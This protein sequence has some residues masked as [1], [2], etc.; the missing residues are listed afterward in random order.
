MPPVIAPRYLARFSCIGGA[1][2]DTCCA[3]W[4]IAID[5]DHY[6]KM[7]RA[8]SQT[9]AERELFDASVKRLRSGRTEA[10]FALIVL[11]QKTQ[12]CNFLAEDGLCGLQ[13]RHGEATLPHICVTYPRRQSVV[14]DR[15]ESAATLSCPEAARLALLHPDAMELV[16]LD[17]SKTIARDLWVQIA[18]G[19]DIYEQSLD[20]V[21]MTMLEI[22]AGAGSLA[23][24]VGTIAALAHVLGDG[25]GQ[26][27]PFDRDAL[28]RALDDFSKPERAEQMARELESIDM[29]LEVPMLPL[30]EVLS[31]RIDLPAGRFG[32][33]LKNAVEAYSIGAE[34]IVADV[35]KAYSA[36]RE[37][38]RALV[39][40]RLDAILVNFAL[41]HAFTYWYTSAPNL[42]VWVRGLVVRIALIRFLVFA[43]PEIAALAAPG[44][45][46]GDAVRTVERV[47]IEV[48]YR[49][50]RAVDHYKSFIEMLDQELPKMMPGLEHALSMLKL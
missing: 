14:G 3:Q 23:A 32:E 6:R 4:S 24:G 38:V 30:L 9:K 31:K 2:E 19:A 26:G 33:V 16:D 5:S 25:F 20:V 41:N 37:S 15:F 34:A 11:N 39:D 27:K 29:P 47:A 18:G 45:T 35:A 8:F 36:R 48:V 22:L 46:E 28:T 7:R 12:K 17:S 40:G 13:Q 21:R 49:L 50:A 42:G 10:K 43:H 1:C 44:T